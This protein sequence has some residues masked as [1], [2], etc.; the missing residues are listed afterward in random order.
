MANEIIYKVEYNGIKEAITSQEALT[1]AIKG[2]TEARNAQDFGT[3]EYKRLNTQ[4]GALKAIREQ[5]NREE[6][7]AKEQYKQTQDAGQRSYRAINAELVR[8]RNTYKDFTEEERN[9]PIGEKTIK[10]IQA[11]DKE[12]KGIDEQLGNFQRNVGNYKGA[13]G[14]VFSQLSGFDIAA[15]AT[16]PTALAAAAEVAIEVG[17]EIFN[18]V[19]GIRQLR[20]EIS[21]LVEGTDEELDG[22]TARVKAISDTFDQS[23]EEIIKTANAVSNAF[24]IS[25]GQALS[26][27]EEGFVAGSNASGEFLQS[28]SEYPKLFEEAGFSADQFFKLINDQSTLGG[29]S[30]KLV[31]TVKEAS[32]SLRELTP[33]TLAAL[34]GIGITEQQ[35]TQVIGDQGLAGAIALVAKQLKTVEADS[36]QAG[37]VLADVFRGAGEDIGIDFVTSLDTA[38]Q[39]TVGLIDKTNEYQVA[40]LRAL[41][42]NKAFSDTLVD[43]S[44]ALGGAG[45]DLDTVITEIETQLLRVLLLA[46][47]NVKDLVEQFEP[48]VE[49]IGGIAESLGLADKNAT[50]ATQSLQFLAKAGELAKKPFDLFIF[51]LTKIGEGIGFVARKT[52]EFFEAIFSPLDKL[53]QYIGLSNKKTAKSYQEF[54]DVIDEGQPKVRKVGEN[55]EENNKKTDAATTKTNS[56]TKSLKSAGDAAAKFA[57]GS[58]A[59]LRKAVQDIEQEFDRARPQ[60]QAG[61]FDKLLVAKGALQA[62]EEAKDRLKGIVGEVKTIADNQEKEF[63]RSTKIT[64]DGTVK[65]VDVV[66]KG[67]RVTGESL[68]GRLS[69]LK[70]EISEA[71]KEFSAEATSNLRTDFQV[72]LD[73]FVEEV[74][75]FFTSGQVFQAFTQAGQAISDLASARNESELKGIEEKYAKDIELAGNNAKKKERLEKELAKER[76]RIQK[77]EFE[78]QKR[79]RVAAAIASGLEGVV[80]ILSTPTTI[81]DPFGSLYKA[82]Q[83]AFLAFTTTKQVQAI[84]AQEAAFGMFIEGKSHAQGGERF[85]INGRP[86]EAEAGEFMTSTEGGGVAIVN[87]KNSR[88]FKDV[89]QKIGVVNF[90]GK[91]AV[92][93]QINAYGGNGIKFEQGGLVEPN[94]T[95]LKATTGFTDAGA[96]S[97]AEI[98]AAV[99]RGAQRGVANGLLTTVRENE[100]LEEAE[101]KSK[102]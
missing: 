34:K 74:E 11:L 81:P 32:I 65:N 37:A 70:V 9:S 38:N 8:L 89:L 82:A 29:F 84:T 96:L 72:S 3:D 88:Q 41:E 22:F 100:R 14:D 36:K 7:L 93:S 57:E 76:E 69:Q 23:T 17:T 35:I 94:F 44:Q 78:Q 15:L 21:I 99:E 92:L 66:E 64:E 16:V 80:N 85:N 1:K 51:T 73:A 46:I 33:A 13:I 97:V 5:L 61:L 50:G 6:R 19:K 79:F 68:I 90:P 83:I 54:F 20:G 75:K 62:A 25:F 58:L 86:I 28:A 24:D 55:L 56:Y 71:S 10:Q 49:A 77:K 67:L 53:S 2:T 45:T 30:D 26:K 102:L 52:Q 43:I 87:K 47:E 40:Q 18:L 101:T 59:Q 12:L 31:D 91:K 42:A 4:L 27:I 95:R 39:A 98:E 48:L 60:D 63:K